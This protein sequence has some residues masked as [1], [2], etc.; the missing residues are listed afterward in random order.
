MATKNNT[1]ARNA[2][3]AAS[4]RPSAGKASG[5]LYASEAS[6]GV[7]DGDNATWRSAPILGGTAA[8]AIVKGTLTLVAGTKT[9]SITGMTASSVVV[10]QLLT[11]NTVTNTV[12]YKAEPGSGSFVATA[13]VAAGTINVADVSVLQYIAIL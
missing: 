6:I 8:G 2:V 11:P 3:G 1:K 5:E 12:Q 13:L 7:Y 9:T 10:M 4:A